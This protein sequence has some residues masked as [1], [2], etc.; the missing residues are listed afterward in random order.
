MES[1]KYL[2]IIQTGSSKEFN[3][4]YNPNSDKS[5]KFLKF[6]MLDEET[7]K[8]GTIYPKKISYTIFNNLEYTEIKNQFI[9]KGFKKVERK[10]EKDNDGND[11]ISVK[12]KKYEYSLNIYTLL[13]G[14]YQ[15]DLIRYYIIK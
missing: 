5:A 9:Q 12:Y 11:I 1:Q 7:E 13:N 15:F 6:E 3:W 10:V 4:E 8:K 2:G 14:R